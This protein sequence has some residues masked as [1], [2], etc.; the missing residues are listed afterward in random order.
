MYYIEHGAKKIVL[1]SNQTLKPAL[2]I[3]K[4]FGFKEVDVDI[5][6]YERA[7]FQAEYIVA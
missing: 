3:Y 7:Y 5:D 6:D 4:S 1:Y 2:H